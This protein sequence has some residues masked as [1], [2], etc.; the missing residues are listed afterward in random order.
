MDANHET[1]ILTLYS[2]KDSSWLEK[3]IQQPILADQPLTLWDDSRLLPGTLWEREFVSV[4]ETARVIVILV[5]ANLL[6]SRFIEELP[7]LLEAASTQ[8][9][10]ILWVA[11]DQ[12]VYKPVPGQDLWN[13][14]PLDQLDKEAQDQILFDIS[15]EIA[16]TTQDRMIE[17]ESQRDLQAHPI[18]STSDPDILIGLNHGELLALSEGM[19][20]PVTQTRL[21]DLLSR[22]NQDDLT[23][24]EIDEL[25]QVLKR[26]D[27]LNILRAKAQYTLEHLSAGSPS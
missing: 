5:S 19:L 26:I 1:Q 16:R 25:D 3:L 12:N 23:P 20:T 27:H 13:T 24:S 8:G 18:S 11:L 21:D 10:H 17:S 6:A 9:T 15:K 2:Q 14:E 4:L 7:P 22:N